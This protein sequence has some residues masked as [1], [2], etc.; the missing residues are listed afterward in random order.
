MHNV[1][2]A[3]RSDSRERTRGLVSRRRALVGRTRIG[4]TRRPLYQIEQFEPNLT[5]PSATAWS[6]PTGLAC[7]GANR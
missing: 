2:M 1:D 6:T 7:A 3:E 5:H 4:C